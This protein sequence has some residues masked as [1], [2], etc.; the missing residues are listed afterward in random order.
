MG[1]LRVLIAEDESLVAMGIRAQ[2]ESL[3]YEVVG[4][5]ADGAEAVSLCE[6]VRPDV[7]IMDIN[8]PRMDGVEAARAI[9]ERCPTP[10][11]ILTGYSD[12]ELVERAADAGVFAYLV[13][14]VDE[15][16]LGPAIEVALARFDEERRLA[17]EAR[18]A[19]EALE[20]RKLVER[21]KGI[22]MDRLGLGEAEAMRLLQKKSR[23]Q[24]KKL[25]DMARQI[26]EADKILS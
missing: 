22:L 10:V 4:E 18:S 25:V 5:A 19:R 2:L 9:S 14:P 16:D 11:V 12:R 3:G 24:N 8:M 6:R 13:K 23:D 20:A 17:A 21:A 15:H 1:T 7:V 26:I